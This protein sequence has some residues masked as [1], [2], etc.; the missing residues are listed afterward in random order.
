AVFPVATETEF[1]SA[2]HRDYGLA[3][4]GLGPKQSA[5]TVA[6]AIHAA[7]LRPRA[8]VYPHA[9][10]RALAVLG[11]VAPRFTDRLVRKYARRRKPAAKVPPKRT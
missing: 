7:I 6:A 4:E 11:V 9:K 2:M 3:V 8:E 10:A 5:D 1:H